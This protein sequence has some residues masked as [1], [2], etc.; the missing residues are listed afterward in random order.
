MA[1]FN[2]LLPPYKRRGKSI[3]GYNPIQADYCSELPKG[4]DL[5]LGANQR[6]R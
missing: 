1:E 6:S 5:F 2:A 4:V 3:L